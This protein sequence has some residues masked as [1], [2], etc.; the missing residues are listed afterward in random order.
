ML[1]STFTDS[2]LLLKEC[3]GRAG[4]EFWPLPCSIHLGNSLR[5]PPAIISLSRNNTAFSSSTS[6][7]SQPGLRSPRHFCAPCCALFLSTHA[8]MA[9]DTSTSYRGRRA[10]FGPTYMDAHAFSPMRSDRQQPYADITY[11]VSPNQGFD[12]PPLYPHHSSNSGQFYP[13]QSPPAP[14]NP[15]I[16]T[17]NPG[18]V[19]LAPARPSPMIPM[20]TSG[21]G[22]WSRQWE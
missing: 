19:S 14:F 21:P 13:P 12:Q 22:S 6:R 2:V 16:T 4:R 5:L 17:L 15:F 1:L 9:W 8:N 11:A 20:T 7:I 10:G 3:N 18:M